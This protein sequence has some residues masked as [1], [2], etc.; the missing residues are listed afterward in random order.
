MPTSM[1]AGDVLAERYRLVDLLAESGSGRFWR[2]HDL[3]LDRH[4]A[5][6]IHRRRRRPRAGAARGRAR[7]S[8]PSPTAG[9]CGCS[10]PSRPTSV[11]YVVN[12]WGSGDSL[13]I[14][15]AREGPLPPAPRGLAGRRG[16][17]HDRRGPRR[18][19]RP[20]PPRPE[21][22]LVDQHGQVRI[23]GF[24]VDAALHGAATGPH[25]EWT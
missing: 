5:V 7:R 6:H 11:C 20:R 12:E 16:R 3:V 22:V 9:C 24:G 4:V 23:I 18:R 19:A 2:A 25:R 21:N 15:V 1:Q 10:T 17:R 8:A 13:D 14:L